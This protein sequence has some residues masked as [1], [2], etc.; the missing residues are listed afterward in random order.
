M[1]NEKRIVITGMGITTPIGDNP[2]MFLNNLLEG[3]SAITKWKSLD[4][5]RI[6]SKIGGDLSDYVWKYKHKELKPL[7]PETAYKKA[8]KIMKTAPFSTRITMLTS[9]KAYIDAELFD[10]PKLDKYTMCA[11]IGG[12]NYHT[13]YIIKNYK[14][15][16]DEPEFIDGLMGI[17]VYDT[18]IITS[19]AEA[20]EIYGPVYSVG[21]TCTSSGL[22]MRQA[23]NEIRYGDADV[24]L[25]A[26]GVL[27]YSPL[28][29]QALTLINAISYKSFNDAPEKA[30]RPYDTRREGFVPSHAAGTLIL[31]SYEHAKRRGAKIYAEILGVEAN[32]DANHLSNPSVEGQSRLMKKV[33]DKTGVRPEQIDY[34]NAHA[35]STPIGDTI[36]INSIKKVFG[37]YAHNLKVNATK[38]LIGHAGWSSAVVELIGAILQM[39]SSTLH[40]SINIDELDPEV[41]IDVCA[42]KKVENYNIDYLLKNSFG[43]GGLNCCVVIK[44]YKD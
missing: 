34:I 38:S 27:D 26:G 17:V 31:E 23:L 16:Q 30:S 43:F 36:E 4:V 33:L 1:N 2:R 11:I 21:G 39:R 29:L 41:D 10:C 28:D 44:K 18:D 12:H 8:R 37:D 15:F 6:E 13:N 19:V 25:V 5:D 7:I 40:P 14:Q 3:K 20:L 9:L 42:N 22:A 35:T 32:S 24:V